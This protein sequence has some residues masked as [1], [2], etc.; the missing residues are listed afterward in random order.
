MPKIFSWE[1][2]LTTLYLE[3]VEE[4]KILLPEEA[5][6]IL[7]LE[8][9]NP[10]LSR[11]EPK[12]ILL[13]GQRFLEVFE[14]FESE[15]KN[16]RN[17]IYPPEFLP[18][19]AQEFL[20][21]LTQRYHQFKNLLEEKK[22]LFNSL[23]LPEVR[24]LLKEKA[25]LVP[26]FIKRLIFAGFAALK[27]AEKEIFLQFIQIFTQNNLPMHIIF[28]DKA[29]PHPIIQ[30]TLKALNLEAQLIPEEYLEIKEP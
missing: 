16:P 2:F 19:K 11:E 20:E 22:S 3:L 7:F 6:L 4:P 9:L 14:E 8:V 28:A 30:E 25:N 17:L 12:S 27:N 29:P 26:S 15:G 23:L 24:K 13:W 10:S 5:R 21:N 1:E 18:E